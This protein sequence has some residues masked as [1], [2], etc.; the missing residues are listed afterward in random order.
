MI[1]PSRSG[2]DGPGRMAG[3]MSGPSR[4]VRRIADRL[5]PPTRSTARPDATPIRMALPVES[6]AS[7]VIDRIPSRH[8]ERALG[9]LVDGVRPAGRP[10]DDRGGVDGHR[11]AAHGHLEPGEPLRD[12]TQLVLASVVVLRT[13]ARAF[14]PLALLAE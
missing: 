9:G 5:A 6:A 1:G 2:S 13:V 10:V 3:G 8:A 7:N 4:R 11:R 12:G 14:E